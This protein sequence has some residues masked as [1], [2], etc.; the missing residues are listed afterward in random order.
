MNLFIVED[1]PYIQNRLIRFVEELPDIHVVGVCGEVHAA[2]V[3]ILASD[4][5]AMILDVQL[6]DGNGLQLLKNIKLSKPEIKVVVLT[7][8]ATEANRMQALRAGADG[9][10]DKSTDFE[11]IPRILHDWQQSTLP[12][13]LN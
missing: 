2:Y 11:Q 3:E 1:S 12:Q 8:H 7:N 5:E 10:L 4:A 6:S 9:F 13:N